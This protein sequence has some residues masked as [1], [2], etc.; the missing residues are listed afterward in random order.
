MSTEI[1]DDVSSTISASR[2][3]AMCSHDR[4]D[5]ECRRY[6]CSEKGEP[7]GK[8]VCDGQGHP[9]SETDAPLP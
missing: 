2:T 3:T 8:A 6:L 9:I 7:Y 5:R 1:I 4:A